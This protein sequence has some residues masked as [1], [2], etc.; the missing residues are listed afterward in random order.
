VKITVYGTPAAQGSKKGFINRKT[1]R[2]IIVEQ[3]TGKK[4]KP[5]REAV[6]YAA[7][8]V[9]A[10]GLPLSGPLRVSMVFTFARPAGHFG[11]GKN[12]GQVRSSAPSHPHGRPDLSKLARSTEDALT[13]ARAY[14]DDSRIVEYV[15]LAKVY[16]DGDVDALDAPGVR[17][18]IMTMETAH[19]LCGVR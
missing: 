17:I 12:A 10:G 16:I 15:R 3:D 18:E 5:W 11:S 19:A 7:I 6:K 4:L 2:V 13:D 14:D 1:N 9:R 8:E